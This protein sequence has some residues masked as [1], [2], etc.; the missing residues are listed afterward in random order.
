MPIS[1]CTNIEI[2]CAWCYFSNLKP[3]TGITDTVMHG[4]REHAF[5]ESTLSEVI[6]I[7][8]DLRDG[9]SSGH[10]SPFSDCIDLLQKKSHFNS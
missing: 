2:K 5:N 3:I 1:F 6:F 7:P 10:A 4:Y 9:S 8:Q